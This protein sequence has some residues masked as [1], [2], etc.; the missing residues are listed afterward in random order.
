MRL[1]SFRLRPPFFCEEP[2]LVVDWWIVAIASERSRGKAKHRVN[3]AVSRDLFLCF[4][5]QPVM[6][7]KHRDEIE[8]KRA[9]LQELR[10]A[11][12][13]RQ[14]HDTDRRLS[15]S[16]PPCSPTYLIIFFLT[17][18]RHLSSLQHRQM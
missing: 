13:N 1:I 7:A 10:Q 4:C 17:F 18:S 3:I 12:L 11:R 2:P 15:V 8:A 5:L 6:S 9:K 14:K 16:L